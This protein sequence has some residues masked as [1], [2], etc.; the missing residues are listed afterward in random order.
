MVE[1]A[2]R[3]QRQMDQ[4]KQELTV[5]EKQIDKKREERQQRVEFGGV[6]MLKE[7][8]RMDQ[9]GKEKQKEENVER[10][11]QQESNDTMGWPEQ[12]IDA[13]GE[14][15][16]KEEIGEQRQQQQR[17]YGGVD[18]LM[19]GASCKLNKDSTIFCLERNV[20]NW[21]IFACVIFHTFVGALTLSFFMYMC[22][23]CLKK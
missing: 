15:R 12:Q 11:G 23:A 21:M 13:E 14:E 22:C 18:K 9:K 4:V 5:C 8:P 19:Q 20:I 7:E 2:R 6:G 17:D 1:E 10:I 3:T 16:V